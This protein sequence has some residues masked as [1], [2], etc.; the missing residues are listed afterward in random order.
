MKAN[1][2]EARF[3]YRRLVRALFSGRLRFAPDGEELP[4]LRFAVALND[5][6]AFF[7]TEEDARRVVLLA[8]LQNILDLAPMPDDDDDAEVLDYL[9]ETVT[10]LKHLATEPAVERTAWSETPLSREALSIHGMVTRDAMKY[11]RWLGGALTG[12]GEVIEIGSWLGRSTYPLAQGL[13]VNPSFDGHHLHAVDRFVWSEWLDD[14]LD[15]HPEEFSPELR[16]QL[17]AMSIGDSYMHLFL[18]SCSEYKR[19]IKPH[20][21][22]V[23]HDGESGEIP[24]LSWGG[25]PVELLTQDITTSAAQMQKIWDIF[26]PSFIPNKTV[27][28]LQT[29]GHMRAE[30]LRRF[31]REKADVLTPIHK[32]WGAAKAF[33]FTG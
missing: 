4:L 10:H 15:T 21:R 30:G 19:F 25:E 3:E 33:R 27:L 31:C 28:V 22:V 17:E 20:S 32:P 16:A 13:A 6:L 18:E 24:E 14:Y 1:P 9:L 2:T 11:Y 23:Y 26:R 5:I 7:K 12:A 8:Q 29:Y